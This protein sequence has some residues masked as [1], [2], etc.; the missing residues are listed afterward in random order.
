MSSTR[1]QPKRRSRAG[2]ARV[3]GGCDDIRSIRSMTTIYRF[4]I[5]TTNEATYPDVRMIPGDRCSLLA[6]AQPAD[7]AINFLPHH[8]YLQISSLELDADAGDE[9][10][11]LAE[12]VL[13]PA[14]HEFEDAARK[15]KV[16]LISPNL[17]IGVVKLMDNKPMVMQARKKYRCVWSC[18][19]SNVWFLEAT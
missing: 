8:V 10:T 16:S 3:C 7:V 1:D 17:A 9:S 5:H 18:V 2:E 15:F 11:H 6:T 12:G 19:S 13:P 14:G 4:E